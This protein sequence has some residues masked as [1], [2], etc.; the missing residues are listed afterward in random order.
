LLDAFRGA[1]EGKPY[2]HR[3]STIGDHIAEWLYEDLFLLGKS[4]AFTRRINSGEVALNVRNLRVGVLARRGDGTLG[5]LVPGSESVR[6]RGF[7]VPRGHIA[8]VEIGV[9]VKI[10]AKSMIKQID[11]VKR[12][13]T[14][15]VAEFRKGGGRPICIGI[16]GI[17]WA[18]EYHSFE[19]VKEYDTK[20]TGSKPHP[21]REAKAAEE[22][23]ERDVRPTF[24]E[25]LVLRYRATNAP[26]YP[27][28]WVDE[29]HS[30]LAYGA[31]LTRIS[32]EYDE[33][34]G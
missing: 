19:G 9:E 7:I 4:K 13:L 1:F 24:D 10:L 26:P 25:F 33:R 22:R 18:S 23:L 11:R 31:L 3:N 27:F 34:F 32:R 20:G 15:Q 5:E 16:V 2:I 12:D 8:T 29:E 28:S 6:D 30:S 17:N 21:A 14:G